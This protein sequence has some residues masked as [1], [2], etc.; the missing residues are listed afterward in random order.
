MTLNLNSSENEEIIIKKRGRKPTKIIQELTEDEKLANY[1]LVKN[2]PKKKSFVI[3]NEK[4]TYFK[5]VIIV[6]NCCEK[7]LK[8]INNSEI[9]KNAQEN[10]S[11]DF[12]EQND[13]TVI[14]KINTLQ[15]N[16]NNYKTCI[17]L[18]THCFWDTCFFDWNPFIIPKNIHNN[19]ING[20]GHFCSPEC[21]LAFLL[22]E[23]INESDKKERTT[24]LQNIYRNTHD[25]KPILP[26]TTP[27]YILDIYGG[28][29]TIDE[30]RKN[31]HILSSFYFVDKPI[32]CLYS[33]IL[34]NSNSNY[35][36]NNNKKYKIK[37]ASSSLSSL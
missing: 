36:Q 3:N 30:Y 31:F 5:E 2:K 26:A 27:Y 11:E 17:K 15:N 1:K 25:D 10:K 23:N 13:K 22:K 34:E 21:A 28:N 24:L 35:S 8:K 14:S 32:A 9:N 19:T 33:E 37:M 18:P 12:Y 6:L 29:L 7:D 20:Y 4:K 16:L